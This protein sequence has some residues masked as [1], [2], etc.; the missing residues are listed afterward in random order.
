MSAIKTNI[1]KR[2]DTS[3]INVRVCCVKLLQRIIQVQTAG[4]ITDPR[5]RP[6]LTFCLSNLY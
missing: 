4:V 5:V 3:P 6:A 2:M 1:L